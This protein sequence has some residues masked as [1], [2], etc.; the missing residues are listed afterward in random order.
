[1]NSNYLSKNIMNKFSTVII[2]L[3]FCLPINKSLGQSEWTEIANHPS[4]GIERSFSFVIDEIL[5]VGCGRESN[6]SNSIEVWAYDI[7]T[8]T[9]IQKT[10]F[11][12]IARR[13]PFAFHAGDKG[14]M[15]SGFDGSGTLSDFWRY[16][17]QSD[18]WTQLT[19]FPGGG[20]NFAVSISGDN[21]GYVM[22][23]R[24]NDAVHYNDLWEFDSQSE[25]WTMLDNFP[26]PVRW[27]A[28]GWMIEDTIYIGAGC[29]L[30][31]CAFDDLYAY[32][33]TT[34]VWEEKE[35]CPSN[36]TTGGFSFSIQDKGYYV[37]GSRETISIYGNRTYVYDSSSNSWSEEV[38][39]PG[40][41]R[42][43]GFCDVVGNKA[44]LG[45]G[46]NYDSNQF[47]NDVYTFLPETLSVEKYEESA[48]LK[49]FPNPVSDLA[50]FNV[51]SSK[52]SK[53]KDIHIFNAHGQKIA[54]HTDRDFS[55]GVRMNSYVSGLYFCEII[56]E[57]NKTLLGKFIVKN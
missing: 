42:G 6:N 28:Y 29:D 22:S 21:K 12:G 8:D 24:L 55:L 23:G 20:R 1:M 54:T 53:I 26:G 57:D 39:F 52:G 5:Y 3:S 15:G 32:D 41:M 47:Y 13:N 30:D 25:T 31:T 17:P 9:W 2:L 37:E 11:P 40:E 45:T 43:M 36:R 35:P 27:L 51:S 34:G 50:Y 18:S 46:R 33:L 44:I 10:D 38:M 56:T 19:N 48:A 7:E 16:D 49:I 4:I 14:Y